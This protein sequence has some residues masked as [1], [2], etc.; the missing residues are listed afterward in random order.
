M[1]RGPLGRDPNFESWTTCCMFQ[2]SSIGGDTNNLRVNCYPAY[3]SNILLST[4][5]ALHLAPVFTRHRRFVPL[6]A[7]L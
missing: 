3:N 7:P 6:P 5:S 2:L 1:F 4:Q